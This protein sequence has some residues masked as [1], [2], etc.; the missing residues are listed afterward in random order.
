VASHFDI[1]SA[2]A[3]R[4]SSPAAPA[5][6]PV[7]RRRA[8]LAGPAV[9]LVT[10]IA[11]LLA[12]DDAGARFRDPDHVAA[13]YFVAVG[14]G[15]M[16]LVVLDVAIRAARATGTRRPTREAMAAVR[17]QRWTPYR[18]LAA[19]GALV[20]FYV[21]YLSY[22]NLKGTLPLL[23]PGV[24]F[25]QELAAIDRD[26]FGGNDP[27]ELLHQL[28]GTGVVPAHVLSTVYAAF[29]VFLPLC[30]GLA[31][32]FA[33]D[34]PT[35]LFFVTA[36]SINWVLGIATYYAL[37]AL[38]PIYADPGM[39]AALPHTQVTGLQEILLEHRT[40]YLRDPNAGTP[41]AIAAFASLH[42]AMSV[43][44]LL[45]AYLLGLGPRVKAAL[46]TWL[47]LTTL[48]TIY[49]GWHYVLDD[50]AGLAMA[51]VSLVMARAMTG[52]DVRAARAAWRARGAPAPAPA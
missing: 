22:R 24:L 30:M 39:F 16:L 12:T 44:P 9:A 33:P 37:P 6:V 26:L 34:L 31:L 43:T 1:H 49:F 40:L 20:S 4:P 46:W 36:L 5:T 3:S 52:Y 32:V 19:G 51:T 23:R 42:I 2:E 8:A 11:A 28:L 47:V 15:V 29:I 50:V 25:D 18:M 13:K 45:A 14:F 35:S 38:G 10:F 41:Q 17:R 21:T 48:A 7:S 27:A